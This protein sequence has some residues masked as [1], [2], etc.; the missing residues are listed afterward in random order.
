M[1]FGSIP[2]AIFLILFGSLTI[3]PAEF[4]KTNVGVALRFAS[5]G[6]GE[7]VIFN[8]KQQ[9]KKNQGY[10]SLF[11]SLNVDSERSARFAKEEK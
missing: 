7:E 2:Q 4:L 8:K 5:S 3:K 9:H 6:C 1:P 11:R 10:E